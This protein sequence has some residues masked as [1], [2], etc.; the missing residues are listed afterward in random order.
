[1]AASRRPVIVL[2]AVACCLLGS[3]LGAAAS[4]AAPSYMSLSFVD[5]THGW[6]AGIDDSYNSTVWRTSDGG[7]TWT[8][9]ASRIAAGG[10]IGWV[11][12]VSATWG[13]W[14]YGSL[15]YTGDAGD[16]WTPVVASGGNHNQA[17]FADTLNGWAV[18]SWGSSESGG[19]ITHTTDG[20]TS[21]S[22]QLDKPGA[23]GSG[24]FTRV[25]APTAT[26]C[27]ALKWGRSSGVFATSDAGATWRRTT[28][29][30]FARKYRLYRDVDFPRARLGWTVGDAGR[31]V[32]TANGGGRWVKQDSGCSASLT[33]VDFVDG[34]VGYVAGAGGRVLKTTDGGRHWK[35]LRTGTKKG[36]LAVCFVDRTHGWVAGVRG[37]LLA[38]TD[39][40]RTWSGS[41]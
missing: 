22:I 10:G 13:V 21:W 26:R 16:T 18:Y 32:K 2:V 31:I 24:G 12:F 29:P 41:H 15:E 1:M 20:G 5:R 39:G 30:A 23:D 36:L 14:G 6:V 3:A 19:G 7:G 38:T 35:R 9:V 27:Y 11:S 28:P 4:A 40:G 33:A 17:S 25:S 34:Q 37:V 8:P